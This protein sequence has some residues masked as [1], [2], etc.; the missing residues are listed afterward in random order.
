VKAKDGVSRPQL[1]RIVDQMMQMWPGR[2]H[3]RR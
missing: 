1:H 3:G 2:K